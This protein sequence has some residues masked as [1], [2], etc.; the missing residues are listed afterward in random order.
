MIIIILVVL[1]DVFM[2][3]K[4]RKRWGWMKS[5]TNVQKFIFIAFFIIVSFAIY[6]VISAKYI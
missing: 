2:Y 3:G 1:A 5:W 4:D 6:F